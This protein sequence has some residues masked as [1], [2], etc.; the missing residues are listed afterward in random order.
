MGMAQWKKATAES[1][2]SQIFPPRAVELIYSGTLVGGWLAIELVQW[3]LSLAAGDAGGIGGL[4]IHAML[5]TVTVALRMF[6]L[7]SIPFWKAGRDSAML[8]VARREQI[9]PRHILM[10]LR[11]W[12]PVLTSSLLLG[13]RY[14]AL[15]FVASLLAEQIFLLTPFAGPVYIAAM[16]GGDIEAAM[17][18]LMGPYLLILLLVFVVLALPLFYR[19]RMVS[20]L[21]MDQELGG[22]QA[23]IGSHDMTR[24]RRWQLARLDLSF[25]W[26]H[27]PV[28]C[29]IGLM[30]SPVLLEAL[31]IRWVVPEAVLLL[32]GAAL[33]L[34]M[35]ALAGHRV[36]VTYAHCYEE[37]TASR[38]TPKQRPAPK[39][40]DLPWDGWS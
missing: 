39:Q 31:E 7:A 5:S 32:V 37:F 30:L 1:L 9:C 15:A 24:Y 4:G 6:L 33:V 10:G 14:A 8:E 29:G 13:L 34:G 16:E 25:W 28:L 36:R 20:F 40:E 3:L 23:M 38:P 27:L 26:Y 35:D 12:K 21:I 19:Y 17:A 18:D 2:G 11:R 22:V